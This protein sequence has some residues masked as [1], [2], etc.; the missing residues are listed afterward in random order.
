[1]TEEI[2]GKDLNSLQFELWQECNSLCDYCYLG[3][4]N[5]KTSNVIK[6]RAIKDAYEKISDL[7][8]YSGEHP[9]QV[10]SYLGGEFF[11][12]QLNTP[13]IHDEFMKLMDKTAWLFNN[14]YIQGVWIYAT[15][16]IGDQKEMYETLDKFD[17]S[18]NGFW[19]LT[20][21]DT[22]GRF[23]TPKMLETWQ[24]HMN[25]IHTKYPNIK[26]NTTTIITQ[27]LIE[28]YNNGEFSF[29]DFKRKYHTQTFYKQC[30][31]PEMKPELKERITKNIPIEKR[32]LA[33]RQY[34][35]GLMNNKFFPKR[36]DMINFMI[37]VYKNE[38]ASIFDKIFNITYRCDDLYR[39]F[40]DG[41]H[42]QHVERQKNTK[43]EEILDYDSIP[44][45]TC[46]HLSTYCCY[47]DSDACVMC[48]KIKILKFLENSTRRLPHE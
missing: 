15:M 46:G 6:L 21:Y 42:M 17:M 38:D 43:L 40:N 26:F 25:L 33:C 41:K 19:L 11:Q 39:N 5:R 22:I 16:T 8:I 20:S 23:H 7:S 30:I 24:Y 31:L 35:N 4:E 28:K 12:G 13:E 29:S 48:D 32:K 14:N 3:T 45:L 9:V 18:S 34:L 27:D 2:S 1:M 37:S 44:I 47:S 10:L 36:Q